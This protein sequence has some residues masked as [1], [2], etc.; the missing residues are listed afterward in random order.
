M[1]TSPLST[2]GH[3]VDVAIGNLSPVVEMD[4]AAAGL[5]GLQM[6]SIN[7]RKAEA[8]LAAVR[9]SV[10]S[11]ISAE[12]VRGLRVPNAREKAAEAVQ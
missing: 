7:I 3:A 4:L 5:A 8:I 10:E 6:A 1:Q 9:V 2:I 12:V 11:I